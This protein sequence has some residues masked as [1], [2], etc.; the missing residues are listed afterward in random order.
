MG[1]ASDHSGFWVSTHGDIEVSTDVKPVKAIAKMNYDRP[2]PDGVTGLQKMAEPLLPQLRAAM[3][4][5]LAAN[6][7]RMIRCLL[8]ECQRTPRLLDCSPRSLFGG[9]IQAA[10][11]G[12]ELG[13]P[14]GQ[15]YLIPFKGEAQLVIGYKG[16]IT[17]AHRSSKVGRITPRAVFEGDTFEIAYGTHQRL[18][19]VPCSTPGKAIGYYAVVEMSNGGIDFEYMTH[20]QVE[21]HRD[22]FA[23]SKNGPWA[24]SFDEMAKKTVIRKL[25]KRIPLSVE[26]VQAAS[27]DEMADEG[28]SQQ[29]SAAVILEAP[30]DE[31]K[32]AGLRERLDRAK[33]PQDAGYDPSTDEP[34]ADLFENAGGAPGH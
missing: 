21:A 8:T 31:E 12:L 27:L 20:A 17:L 32:P 19:H 11:L 25:A 24:G 9:V 23:L 6:A 16:F 7:E 14:A 3:P 2:S 5:Y 18:N 22:R 34:P 1:C 33:K 30:T 26:W 4:G 28:V 29:L 15:A 10:Q 13:G